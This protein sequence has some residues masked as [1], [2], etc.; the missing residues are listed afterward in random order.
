MRRWGLG[1]ALFQL[2]AGDPLAWPFKAR[3][4][5]WE[6]ASEGSRDAA[7]RKAL[8]K[9]KVDKWPAG[10]GHILHQSRRRSWSTPDPGWEASGG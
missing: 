6:V 4:W 5:P 7:V 8:A 2:A 3:W 9:A 10:E 1:V